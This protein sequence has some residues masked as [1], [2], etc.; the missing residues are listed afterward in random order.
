V[1]ILT[2]YAVS[3]GSFNNYL[4][5]LRSRGLIED[6]GDRLTIFRSRIHALGSWEPLPGIRHQLLAQPVG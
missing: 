5:A 2:G 4:G 1:A 3:G 6:D